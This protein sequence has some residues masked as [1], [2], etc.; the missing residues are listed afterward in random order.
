[1]PEYLF[2]AAA[3]GPR[4]LLIALS[5][6]DSTIYE[7]FLTAAVPAL[8]RGYHCLAFDGPGQGA[9]LIEHGSRSARIGRRC[10]AQ[11]STAPSNSRM[12]IRTASP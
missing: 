1:M 3:D 2:R 4:P 5:G 9:V 8:R 11:S 7:S 12:S 10:S 6:Y